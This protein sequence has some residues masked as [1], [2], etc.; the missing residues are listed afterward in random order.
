MILL[1]DTIRLRK[2][3]SSDKDQ[4]FILK[5][6]AKVASL[7]GGFNTF[8]SIEDI[9]KWIDYHNSKLDEVLFLIEDIENQHIVGHVGLYNIDY[10]IRKCEYAIMIADEKY[11]GRGVGQLCTEA[12]ISFARDQLNVQKITLSLL[13]TNKT[14]LSLYIKN[15]FVQE[16]LLKREQYKD[17]KYQD[18]ILMAKFFEI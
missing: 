5:N 13:S 12:M 4:M 6:N 7:L 14:A 17:G 15:G 11:Q 2:A 8:Y 9:S 10:R 3:N 16:G 1:N 18:V